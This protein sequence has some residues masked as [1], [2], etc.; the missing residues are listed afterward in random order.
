MPS[1]K[2]LIIA[3]RGAS[4]EYPE[5]TLPAYGRAIE[6][7]VDYI[8]LDLHLSRDGV[9]VCHHDAELKI[10]SPTGAS[11]KIIDYDHAEIQESP[12]GNY[13]IP[14]LLDVLHLERHHVGLM[15]ELKL[16]QNPIDKLVA[17]VMKM[18]EETDTLCEGHIL[19]GSLSP[20]L[21]RAFVQHVPR[22]SRIGIVACEEDFPAHLAED[23]LYIGLYHPL[24]TA[25]RVKALIDT[26]HRVWTWTVNDPN[27]AKE[28]V[29]IGVSGIITDDPARIQEALGLR[30]DSSS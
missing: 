26:G 1:N 29:E 24:A 6:L 13:V 28:L 14:S 11:R 5:N 19:I 15:L 20:E 25:E 27:R 3:H 2:P 30:G 16:D 18:V 17:A 10:P 7:G 23:P 9:P 22:E 4:A 21:H 12:G 8:E